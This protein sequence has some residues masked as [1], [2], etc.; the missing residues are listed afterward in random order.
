MKTIVIDQR[1]EGEL[2]EKQPWF[3][4]KIRKDFCSGCHLFDRCIVIVMGFEEP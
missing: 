1:V 4:G 2:G 3:R